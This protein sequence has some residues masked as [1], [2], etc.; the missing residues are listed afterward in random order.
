M[1][2]DE[3]DL[4]YEDDGITVDIRKAQNGILR[5]LEQHE[6]LAAGA[7]NSQFTNLTLTT[8]QEQAIDGVRS[9]L[10]LDTGF[11]PTEG[12]L[13]TGGATEKH[14]KRHLRK[15]VYVIGGYAGTGKTLT[16]GFLGLHLSAHLNVAF[17]APTGKASTVL[18][19]SL[20][21][22]GVEPAY[23]GTVHR[24]IYTPITDP[25]TGAVS[26]W[27][28]KA[29]LDLEYDL[30]VVDE[31][32]MVNSTMLE[33]LLACNV[34]ILA[35]GDHG[36]LPPVGEDVNLM[37]EPDSKLNTVHRQA[38]DNPVVAFATEV[39][40]GGDWRSILRASRDP[41]LQMGSVLDATRLAMEAF[42]D[43]TRPMSQDPLL[44]CGKNRTRAM[45]NTA[46]RTGMGKELQ[47]GDRVICLRNAYLSGMLLAN[48]FRGVVDK[49]YPV[50]SPAHLK[51]R[52]VFADEGLAL[53]DG[54]LC[55]AQFGR[56]ATFKE[57][58]E[59]SPDYFNWM[60]VGLL[61][62][63]GN[64]LTVHKAQGSQSDDVI[65]LVEDF[66]GS[67]SDFLRWL[68]TASTRCVKRL[69]VLC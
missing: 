8:E 15:K 59:V 55:K 22:G 52:V 28:R 43:R 54:T 31:A 34:P 67:T 7:E 53:L 14:G 19:R 40:E 13:R 63:F 64:A 33:D 41:R 12:G 69:T 65:L 48:G 61:L 57:F 18:G 49:L 37:A 46:A 23:C 5:R 51:A 56:E 27:V 29:D 26:G 66:Q 25:G 36:Q 16:T 4:Q 58:K 24:L 10:K 11:V 32:S 42:R 39:R 3:D 60:D 50:R 44:L 30:I 20:R 9:W 68:Y 47:V 6:Q 35:V 38:L 1:R 62:D 2:F 17:C 21:A 45:L